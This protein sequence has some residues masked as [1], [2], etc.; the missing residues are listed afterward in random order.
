MRVEIHRTSTDLDLAVIDI[1][2]HL[3]SSLRHFAASL[4]R[5][6][7][8]V[9]VLDVA[10]FGAARQNA[11]GTGAG[12]TFPIRVYHNTVVLGPLCAPQGRPCPTCLET[13]WLSLRPTAE[14]GAIADG[15][16][17]LAFGRNPRVGPAAL[18]TI[19][20]VVEDRLL[21]ASVAEDDSPPVFHML[22]LSRL[23]LSKYQLIRDSVCPS[24]ADL[25]D[26]SR[27]LAVP[28]M[29]SRPK[30]SPHS[31]RLRNVRDY[32]FPRDAYINPGTGLLGRNAFL[33]FDNTVS[34]PV[35][36]NFHI[37]SK[38]S[39]HQAWWSGQS[40]TFSKS[41][42]LGFLEGLERHAGLQIRSRRI[43]VFDTYERLKDDALDPRTTGLY[44]P[45]FYEANKPVYM[46]FAPDRKYYWVWGYSFLRQLP[47]L[48]PEQLVYYL[49]YRRE[50]PNFVQD[51][52]SGCAIGSCLEEAMLHGILELIERDTFLIAWFAKLGLPRIDPWSSANPETLFMADR[53][54]RLGYELHLFDLRLDLRVPSVMGLCMRKDDDLGKVIVAAGASLDPEEAL[55]SALSEVASYVP[56]F[57]GRVE[58]DLE[59]VKAM[60]ADHTKVGGISDHALLF[61]LPEMKKEVEFF[62]AGSEIRSVDEVYADWRQQYQATGDLLDDLRFC[63]DNI[64]GL[65]LEV[66][67]VDQT[68]PE[69]AAIGLCTACMIVPGMMPMDFGYYRQRIY[70]LP[71][72]RTVP[73]LTG[74]RSRDLVASDLN[75]TPHPFP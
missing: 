75:T 16:K 54:E 72:L 64:H 6:G 26:D 44:V 41:L 19:R 2:E 30:P 61:G 49:D 71:R 35:S 3:G 1:A 37:K 58:S 14:Q 70:E 42:R 74:H 65:G 62:F 67:M 50:L 15:N 10:A 9:P 31:Y 38:Y 34:A 23:H 36:G 52:S 43:Q 73:R 12:W 46:P 57:K 69:Q 48:V 32:P 47:I 25:P 17:M 22:N 13:R 55:F 21:R 40:T 53:L 60:Y 51:C 24:C 29:S 20:G 63:I 27:E 45:E 68:S 66:V 28:A 7:R 11:E 39:Y 5:R 33:G 4:E 18:E 59:R 8:P 56:G